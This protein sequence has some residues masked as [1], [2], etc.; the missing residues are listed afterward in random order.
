LALC[1]ALK[2]RSDQAVAIDFVGSG[3]TLERRLV[4][5][6]G[7]NYHAVRS[8]KLRRYG[9]GL[10]E[11]VDYKTLA[12]NA[13]DAWRFG[14]GLSDARKLLRKLE[15][16]VVFVKGGY[17]GLPAGLAATRLNIPLVIHE[18]DTVMGLTNRLLAPRAKVIATGFAVDHF[19]KVKATVPIIPTGNPIRS[20]ILAGDP[21]RAR[22]HFNLASKLPTIFFIGGSLGA[23]AIN[24]AVAEAL[25]NLVERFNIIHQTGE[26]DIDAA[27]FHRQRLSVELRDR[28]LPQAFFREELADIYAVADIVV[29]RCGANVL[30]ELAAL[31]KPTIL[32]PLPSSTN[33]HQYKNA[34][35]LVSRG[36]ARLLDQSKLNAISLRAA[37]DRLI[38]S[39]SDQRYLAKSLHKLAILDAAE[40]LADIIIGVAE[41]DDKH[42]RQR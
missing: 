26:R 3:S 34:Q 22:K 14:R 19:Q 41:A 21:S 23:S 42:G 39:E 13:R 17:V 35:F 4:E 7:V 2:S 29:A 31:A 36:A 6:Y 30:A 38:E 20:E 15:P 9:R 11:L 1:A 10:A 28:Y 32:I 8:G 16:D 25:P 18:S 24:E 12:V 37:I 27:M 5:K 40:R 33:N